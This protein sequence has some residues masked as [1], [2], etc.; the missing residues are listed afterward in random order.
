MAI[1]METN[2]KFS[3]IYSALNDKQITLHKQVSGPLISVSIQT[4][5]FI[6]MVFDPWFLSILYELNT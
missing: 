2:N 1:G 3:A 6:N 4:T 5:D